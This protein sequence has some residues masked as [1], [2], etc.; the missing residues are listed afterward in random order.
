MFPPSFKSNLARLRG[1]ASSRSRVGAGTDPML[2]DIDRWISSI[3]PIQ[4][5]PGICFLPRIP[6]VPAAAHILGGVG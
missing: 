4:D 5:L 1:R 3:E 2:R 6:E